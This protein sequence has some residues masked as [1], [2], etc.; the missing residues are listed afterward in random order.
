M[1]YPPIAFPEPTNVR[2][3]RRNLS[4]QSIMRLFQIAS[5]FLTILYAAGTMFALPLHA[6]LSDIRS[7]IFRQTYR[8]V[9]SLNDTIYKLSLT[10]RHNNIEQVIESQPAVARAPFSHGKSVDA[11]TQTGTTKKVSFVDET[12]T[13]NTP[14][15][16]QRLLNATK[17][18]EETINTPS[19]Q[20]ALA[21]SLQEFSTYVESVRYSQTWRALPGGKITPGPN[22]DDDGISNVRSEIRNI[23]GLLLSASNFPGIKNH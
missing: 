18:L 23:K 1:N 2:P 13:D 21:F 8:W 17:Q 9:T 10:S 22:T 12:V 3:R 19:S 15:L 20:P 7:D 5:V 6:Q 4:L 16:L 11:W 14:L